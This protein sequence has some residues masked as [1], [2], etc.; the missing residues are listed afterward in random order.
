M[1]QCDTPLTQGFASIKSGVLEIWWRDGCDDVN[2][3]GRFVPPLNINFEVGYC[4]IMDQLLREGCTK[5]ALL[6]YSMQS[7]VR[8]RQCI[9]LFGNVSRPRVFGH[10]FRLNFS[11]CL[12]LCSLGRGHSWGYL[13]GQGQLQ[14]TLALSSFSCNRLFVETLL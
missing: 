8:R 1:S 10:V 12:Q 2:P 4:F 3:F 13:D 7:M 5:L 6:V 9:M 14:I 11:L